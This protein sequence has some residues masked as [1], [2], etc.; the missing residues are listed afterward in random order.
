MAIP[1]MAKAAGALASQGGGKNKKNKRGAGGNIFARTANTLS[2]IRNNNPN[3]GLFSDG[4]LK[5]GVD[6]KGRETVF[7]GV[8]GNNR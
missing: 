5:K 7:L 6:S 3:K 2:N 4:R 8:F 1:A